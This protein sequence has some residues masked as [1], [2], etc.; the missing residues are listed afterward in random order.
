MIIALAPVPPTLPSKQSKAGGNFSYAIGLLVAAALFAL[1]IVPVGVEPLDVCSP[2]TSTYR[3]V[4]WAPVVHVSVLAPLAAELVVRHLAPAVAEAT[5]RPISLL[6]MVLLVAAAV[7]V[8]IVNG[9]GLISMV[10]N[11]T[12]L[13]L[14]LFT[15]WGWRSVT[16]S[17]A[18]IPAI[19]PILPSQPRHAI[20]DSRLLSQDR[21][22][23]MRR[24]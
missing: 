20:P 23:R 6:A 14:P 5:A 21:P 9:R 16:R 7:P 13:V 4:L 10:G 18:R 12:L 3:R 2:K 15:F 1:V 17:V 24:L 22:F 11:G 19:A 8:I